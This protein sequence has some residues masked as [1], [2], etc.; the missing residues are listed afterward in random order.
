MA[1]FAC[2]VLGVEFKVCADT[3]DAAAAIGFDEEVARCFSD[4]GDAIGGVAFPL[5]ATT[6]LPKIVDVLD[7]ELVCTG[8]AKIEFR[9]P[10]THSL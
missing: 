1:D 7:D 8:L 10:S 5:R 3:V 6:G 4:D 9:R 2:F